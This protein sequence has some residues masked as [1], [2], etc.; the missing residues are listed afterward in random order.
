MAREQGAITPAPEVVVEFLSRIMPFRE[1]DDE[2][3]HEVA[4][5]IRV[6]FFPKGTWLLTMGESE[7]RYLYLIQQGGVKSFLTDEEGKTTLKD[8]R[9]DGE[10]VGALGIIRGTVANMNV[11]T[12]EDTFCF[13]LPRDYF[14]ELINS[15]P[16]FAQYYLKSFSE[17][18]V[19]TA[20]TELRKHRVARRSDEDLFLFSLTVGDIIGRRLRSLPV[21]ASVQEAATVMMRYSVGSLL[22]HGGNPEEIVGIVT[23]K[24]L[25]NKVVAAGGSYALPVGTIMTAPVVTLNARAVCFD[26]LITM[27]SSGIHHL[28]VEEN[29]RIVGVITSHDIMLLQGS[30]PYSLFKEIGRQQY[31]PPLYALAQKIPAVI[32]NLINE[33]AKAGNIVRMI[34]L[35]NDQ[36]LAR[37]L[38][39]VERELGPPPL[40]Y[41]WLLFGSEGRREQAFKTD[42]DNGLLYADPQG[43]EQREQAA[44]YFGRLAARVVD[45]LVNCGYPPC[46]D[47]IMAANPRWCQPLAVWQG[48]FAG[49]IQSG[50]RQELVKALVLFDFR[51]GHGHAALAEELR[52][53]VVR[54]TRNHQAYLA[55]L[56]ADCL[57]AKT[58]PAV[59]RDM[60]VEEDG[61]QGTLLDIKHQG[62]APFVNFARILALRHGIRETNTLARFSV[63]AKEGYLEEELLVKAQEACE[64]QMHLRLIHQ[65][66]QM[67]EGILPDSSLSP[68]ELSEVEKKML[69]DGFALVGRLKGLLQQLLAG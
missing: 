36:M 26:A 4:R 58:P 9:G 34:A 20:Y 42:Q 59:F 41:C 44:E 47:R 27:M 7:V 14:L 52:D 21:T 25:R 53:S 50:D 28:G 16:G 1:L 15:Q 39:L 57:A 54:L 61:R 2:L 68:G 33:G 24:D 48:Y 43:A 31:F 46:A 63:L 30:S 6:D 35:L 45:H 49:W 37:V 69:R 5:R 29:G 62:L 11:E 40:P 23:D 3:L 19:S 17:K 67:E 8:Y 10:Y 22:L 18:I 38:Q 55:P 51:S 64:I 60:V 65:L 56:V 12:V 32:R 13:L 66:H